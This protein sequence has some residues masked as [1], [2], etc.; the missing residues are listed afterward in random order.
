MTQTYNDSVAINGVAD[1]T[2]LKVRGNATQNQPLQTWQDDADN[3]L[4]QVT[5]AGDLELGSNVEVGPPHDALIQV[6]NDI[7]VP[8]SGAPSGLH[9]LGRLTNALSSPVNWVLHEL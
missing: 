4:A 5:G 8:T 1:T 2:Q 9:T 7:S 6:G 3:T